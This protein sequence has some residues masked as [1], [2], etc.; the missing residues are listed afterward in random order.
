MGVLSQSERSRV[1]KLILEDWSSLAMKEAWQE[2][3]RA[4]KLTR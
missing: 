1:W 4:R 3:S 2:S